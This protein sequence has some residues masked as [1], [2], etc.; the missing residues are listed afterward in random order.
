LGDDETPRESQALT[1]QG[2]TLNERVRST[3]ARS[4]D[5]IRRAEHRW[6]K[7][8]L[9]RICQ[10]CWLTQ[11]DGEFDDDSTCPGSPRADASGA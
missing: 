9:G 6:M 5:R 11:A 2:S 8:A 7:V 1:D 4:R 10:V 3:I